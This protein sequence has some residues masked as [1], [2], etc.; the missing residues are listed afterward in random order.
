M[1]Y[2]VAIGLLVFVLGSAWTKYISNDG[3]VQYYDQ[4][5]KDGNGAWALHTLGKGYEF[6]GNW[7]KVLAV[8]RRIVD[9]YPTSTYAMDAQF[10]LALALEKLNRYPEAIQEYQTFLEKY[11]KSAYAQSVRNNIEILKSR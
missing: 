7:E 5:P 1:K 4:H 2:L 11:P 8:D 6:T 10:A 9:R 3:L